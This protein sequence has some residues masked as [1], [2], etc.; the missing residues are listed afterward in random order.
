MLRRTSI[1]AL[2]LFAAVIAGLAILSGVAIWRISADEPLRLSFLTPY[3][4]AA[5]TP[6]D[7]QFRVAISETVLT[8]GGWERTVDLRARDVQAISA[9]GEAI[10][11][12]PQISLSLSLRA[13]L[14]G[15]VA[16][17]AI[18]VFGP[19]LYL[20]RD[21]AGRFA[22]AGL[23]PPEGG[24]PVAGGG[25]V[26]AAIV[27][28]L[29]D[30]PEPDSI[31]GY[32]ARVSL[33]GGRVTLE[34]ARLGITWEAPEASFVIRRS[35]GGLAGEL[36][37][38]VT[39]L[40]S[41]ARFAARLD[42]DRASDSFGIG[43]SFAGLEASAL[44]LVEP[45]LLPLQG[46]DLRLQGN[47]TTRIGLNGRVATTEFDVT[48]GPGQISMPD[49]F[50]APVPL[51]RL[52]LR[53]RLDAG[54]DRLRIDSAAV[55]LGASQLAASLSLSGLITGR[56]PKTG[57]LTISG[58]VSTGNITV[59]TLGQYWPKQAGR[60][61]REWVVEN[62]TEGVAESGKVDFRLRVL[63]NAEA[64]AIDR[65]EGSFDGSGVTL[66]YLKPLPPIENAGGHA[67]FTD[68]EFGVAFTNGAVGRL[69]V[70]GG[71]LRITG[72]DAEDQLI[73]VNGIAAGPLP[74]VLTLLDHPR[75]GYTSELGL[76]PA[77]T[78]GSATAEMSFSFP[79]KK[80]I[81]FDQVKMAVKGEAQDVELSRALFEQNV[82]AGALAIDLDND[83]MDVTGDI[84][85]A[86]LPASLQ[87][88]EN[89]TL[90]EA[91]YQSRFV[92]DGSATA[93]QQ[94]A[95]GLDLRPYLDGPVAGEVVFTRFDDVRTVANADLDLTRT[96]LDVPELIWRKE[97][98]EP[99]RAHFVVAFVD[100]QPTEISDVAVMAGTLAAEG[101]AR[102]AAG[103]TGIE[104]AELRRLELG[105][106][107][108][109]DVN[110]VF[111]PDRPE[112][113]IAGGVIDAEPLMAREDGAKRT[114][115]AGADQAPSAVEEEAGDPL[116]LSAPRLDRVIL[117]EGRELSNVSLLLDHDGSHW[118]RIV[119]DA[120]LRGGSAF[121]VRYQP[122]PSTGKLGFSVIA[123]DAGEALRA[124]DVIDNVV[125][126][127]LTVVGEA[128]E[129]E[130]RRPLRGR[131][132]ISQFRLVRAP[133]LAR[134]LTLATLTGFVDVLTGEGL[135]FSRFTGDFV[136]T[137]GRLEVPLA[138]AYGPS[139]GLTATG[140]LDFDANTVDMQGTIAPAYVVNSILGNI[141]LI[142]DLLQGGKG[143][144][145]FAATYH[146][147]GS[148]SEPDISVNPLAALA[149]GFLRGLFDVFDSSGEASE[150]RAL[151]EPGKKK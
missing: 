62:I 120:S 89:F 144:G 36:S 43:G 58:H 100:D 113:T 123:E 93:A 129:D 18:E 70:R 78:S 19:H 16:P 42:Y 122:E 6:A 63:G 33:V 28:E 150:P 126:G 105:R 41:P 10:A 104:S 72:L 40:G 139:L 9:D 3:L 98:G 51:E 8:W 134:I 25:S 132:E 116:L 79:A 68:K 114:E 20:R 56:T 61:A 125:G 142:G 87:W 12:V 53:G 124:F 149:P 38:S 47:F 84:R 146:A 97:P 65:L 44:V 102:L 141:P 30:E 34:D 135:L 67:S 14:R 86:G 107:S 118:Q 29:Q 112:I 52:S 95:L 81:G 24:A 143:E 101:R 110:V 109:H 21:S 39:Q 15:I 37:A 55:D 22:V 130:P 103:G 69:M 85:L 127:R 4:E 46:V 73:E 13:M 148:L 57:A 23:E 80:D 5:L 131:A 137:D 48:G 66:H 88:R 27:D 115:A 17:T 50:D 1:I 64:V 45:T 82:S 138:R 11:R 26:F 7:G 111:T 75:L 74:D 121:A 99:G 108:L 83:G 128:V 106:T 49:Q 92:L 35:P 31:T 59:S 119:V 2:E 76:D 147:R 77:G 145:V 94:R 90:D 96:T 54:G 133:T 71:K 140:N 136:K 117:G 91:E 151:P 32:L 60:A